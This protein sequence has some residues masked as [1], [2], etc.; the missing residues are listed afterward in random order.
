MKFLILYIILCGYVFAE[1]KMCTDIKKDMHEFE[2]EYIFSLG[3]HTDRKYICKVHPTIIENKL[4][5]LFICNIEDDDNAYA[6]S[7][8]FA[9]KCYDEIT[10]VSDITKFSVSTFNKFSN[11]ITLI[12]S[13]SSE[14]Q[15]LTNLRVEPMFK[16]IPISPREIYKYYP[17]IT[18]LLLA[19]NYSTINPLLSLTEKGYFKLVGKNWTSSEGII[20]RIKILILSVKNIFLKENLTC[21]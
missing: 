16:I 12:Y 20:F 5:L 1:N 11:E 17:E 10:K 6:K 18:Y 9:H 8:I 2:Y 3:V 19:R 14:T 13:Y 7:Y 21:Q 15:K 4:Y